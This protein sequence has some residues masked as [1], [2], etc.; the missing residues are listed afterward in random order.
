MRSLIAALLLVAPLSACALRPGPAGISPGDMPLTARIYPSQPDSYLSQGDLRFTLSRPAYVAVFGVV[1]GRGVGLMYPSFP[2]QRQM[3]SAGFHQPIIS[4][5]FF[6]WGYLPSTAFAGRYSQPRFIYL[7]ASER[8]LDIGRFVVNSMALRSTLGM[9]RFASSNPYSLMEDLDAL[10]VGNVTR[11][12]WTSDVYVVWPQPRYQLARG[13]DILDRPVSL[14]CGNGQV[15]TVPFRYA[16][17]ACPNA[18]RVA[19]QMPPGGEEGDG[20]VERPVRKRPDPRETKPTTTG[21]RNAAGEPG[22]PTPVQR[23]RAQPREVPT[24]QEPRQARPRET[25]PR[26]APRAEPRQVEPT[27]SE[28]RSAPRIERQVPSSPSR[29]PQLQQR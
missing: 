4:N 16:A 21:T 9:Y 28:P 20:K 14:R 3:L 10:V 5:T 6:R 11:G 17:Y 26:S 7:I 23:G 18:N 29:E 8:P 19:G 2:T 12:A 27:R 13:F 25:E 15:V 22:E 1:P 24:P